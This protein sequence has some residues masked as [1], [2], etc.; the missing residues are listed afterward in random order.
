VDSQT[1]EIPKAAWPGTLAEITRAHRGEAVNVEVVGRPIGDQI[2]VV[3]ADGTQT[4]VLLAQ[5][6]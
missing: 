3:G 4:L 5:R 6:T 2:E 1:E